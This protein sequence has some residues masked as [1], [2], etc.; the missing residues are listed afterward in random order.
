MPFTSAENDLVC[1]L[2]YSAWDYLVD[3]LGRGSVEDLLPFVA[4]P[5]GWVA[6]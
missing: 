1:L 4:D 6:N 2:S 3:K 5:D